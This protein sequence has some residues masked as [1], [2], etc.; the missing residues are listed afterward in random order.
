MPDQAIERERPMLPLVPVTPAGT[1][2]PFSSVG[3][4]GAGIHAF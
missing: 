4:V 2:L 3:S 1:R